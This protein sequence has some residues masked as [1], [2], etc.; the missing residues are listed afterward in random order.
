MKS[1]SEK[2]AAEGAALMAEVQAQIAAQKSEIL[3]EAEQLRA[4][5]KAE[6]DSY[7]RAKR[8]EA[9][10]NWLKKPNVWIWI[11][12][13]FDSRKWRNCER[14]KSRRRKSAKARPKITEIQEV[15]RSVEHLVKSRIE[16]NDV[17]G[18]YTA[19]RTTISGS[20]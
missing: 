11:L 8:D 7:L 17:E 9:N 20:L 13:T 18:R 14:L 10:L 12:Q 5:A 19:G 6:A 3:R 2:A 1:Q 16:T 15:A 4:A